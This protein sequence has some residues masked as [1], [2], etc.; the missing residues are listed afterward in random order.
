MRTARSIATL[1]AAMVLL[2]V[3]PPARAYFER[4]EVG[5]RGV[6]LGRAFVASADD[7]S[8]LYWNPAGLAALRRPELLLDYARPYVL[9]DLNEGFGAVAWPLGFGTL[10]AGWHHRSVAD[11]VSEDLFSISLARSGSIGHGPWRIHTGATLKAARVSYDTTDEADYGAL[12][13]VTGDAGIIVRG[14]RLSVGYIVRNIVEPEFDFVSGG[15][16]TPLPRRFD[17]G[18]AYQ[19]HPDSKLVAAVGSGDDDRL[20]ARI[21]GEVV[22]YD[23]LSVRAGVSDARFTGGVGLTARRWRLDSAFVTHPDLGV[24]YRVSLAVPLGAQAGESR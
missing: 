20:D 22:F 3:A 23:V 17:A 6:S 10:A 7:A 12:T 15:G 24:S 14:P 21:G 16:G 4:I 8:A 11:V 2:G 18:A 5:A 1:A 9:D 13:R 19:W